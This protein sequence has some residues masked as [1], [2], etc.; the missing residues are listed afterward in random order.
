MTAYVIFLIVLWIGIIA[1]LIGAAVVLL[2]LF[3][4]GA[5]VCVACRRL[6]GIKHKSEEK[7]NPS[8]TSGPDE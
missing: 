8:G 2:A 3:G 4:G 7:R 6:T 5:A 1:M